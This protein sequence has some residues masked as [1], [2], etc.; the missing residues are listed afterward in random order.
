MYD[1]LFT[2]II[3]VLMFAITYFL[4]IRP[5]RR[6]RMQ[7]QELVD[8]LAR[9]DKVITLGGICGVIKRVEKDRIW[10][11]VQEGVVLKM[12]KESIAEKDSAA[13]AV[14]EKERP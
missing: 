1:I 8:S 3:F 7:H 5:E 10:V 11:E 2:I 14:A 4:I 12:V 6:R 9:G 13:T